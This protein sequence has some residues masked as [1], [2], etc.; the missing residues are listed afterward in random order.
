MNMLYILL[1]FFKKSSVFYK[2]LMKLKEGRKETGK[3]KAQVK[4][5][6]AIA[7]DWNQRTQ[8]NKNFVALGL[9]F[10]ALLWYD[11]T[12][13]RIDPFSL[14]FCSAAFISCRRLIYGAIC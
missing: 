9:D 13:A 3:G 12:A 4:R 14:R 7:S 10:R 11:H 6:E 5:S 2:F 8:Q 1:I